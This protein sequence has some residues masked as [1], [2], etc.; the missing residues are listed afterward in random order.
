MWSR[1]TILG[2]DQSTSLSTNRQWFSNRHWQ[3]MKQQYDYLTQTLRLGGDGG[4]EVTL[5]PHVGTDSSCSSNALCPLGESRAC[6][7]DDYIKKKLQKRKK[8]KKKGSD[9]SVDLTGLQRNKRSY[10]TQQGSPLEAQHTGQQ[11]VRWQGWRRRLC[12][13]LPVHPPPNPSLGQEWQWGGR[14]GLWVRPEDLGE[15]CATQRTALEAHCPK[16]E[17]MSFYYLICLIPTVSTCTHAVSGSDYKELTTGHTEPGLGKNIFSP[18]LL[19]GTSNICI[20]CLAT[21]VLLSQTPHGWA[22]C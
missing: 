12:R 5:P 11:W 18:A 7:R 9:S 16:Q 14:H 19:L 10:S 2:N 6:Q 21:P 22:R 20:G 17:S 8:K 4:N 13:A 15:V 1:V 3:N